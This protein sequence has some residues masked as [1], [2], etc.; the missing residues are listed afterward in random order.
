MVDV[1]SNIS[2]QVHFELTEVHFLA[3]DYKKYPDRVSLNSIDSIEMKEINNTGFTISVARTI[4]A[5]NIEFFSFLVSFDI[6]FS[7]KEVYEDCNCISG[8]E[9]AKN[10]GLK[11]GEIIDACMAR[12]SLIIAQISS[13]ISNGV[14]II[15]PPNI[16]L[17]NY[18]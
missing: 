11:Q 6:D 13:Q 16:L 7:F 18:Q 10:I 9:I 1:F 17:N 3:N 5:E 14:P 8:E 12:I 15:T 4:R 2:N